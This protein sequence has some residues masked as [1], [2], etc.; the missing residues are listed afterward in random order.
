MQQLPNRK[1]PRAEWFDYSSAGVYFVTVCTQDHEEYFGKVVDG[2]MILNEIGKVCDGEI[3][4]LN[5]RETVDIHE[6]VVM[7]NH[8]H[9]LLCMD[10][11]LSNGSRPNE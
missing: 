2:R 6:W 7:P 1:S 4:K 9:L 11:R 3:Q 10:T 8:I 5:H